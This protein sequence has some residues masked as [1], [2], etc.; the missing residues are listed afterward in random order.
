MLSKSLPCI[1]AR[2][3]AKM[4]DG[5]CQE[6]LDSNTRKD[7]AVKGARVLCVDPLLRALLREEAH[8]STVTWNL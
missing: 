7:P 8:A 3:Y 5:P 1:D 4:D 2:A 6:G